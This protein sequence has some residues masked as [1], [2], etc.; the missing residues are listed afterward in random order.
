MGQ[1]AGNDWDAGYRRGRYA[2][3]RRPQ[4]QLRLDEIAR[5]VETITRRHGACEVADIGCGEGLLASRLNSASITRYVGV[6]LSRT[7]L[8]RMPKAAFPVSAVC[9]ALG[10]WDGRPVGN[11]P[12]VLIASEVLY[13]DAEGVAHLRRLAETVRSTVAVI[14]SCVAGKQ[15]KPNWQTAS[16]RLW[17]ELARAG[18][19]E[20]ARQHL[21][22]GDL[23]WDIAAYDLA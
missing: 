2:F 4:E 23:A 8:S 17:R 15:D 22:N 21:A 6:D 14:V 9:S 5:I 11:A 12:R 13:Y 16:V 3:L 19:P 7:A 18:W 10:D 20:L 1:G